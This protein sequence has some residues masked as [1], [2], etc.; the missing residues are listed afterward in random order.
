L[1]AALNK[2]RKFIGSIVRN[3]YGVWWTVMAVNGDGAIGPC[4]L[5]FC[6]LCW[7]PAS[8][9]LLF[10]R[11]DKSRLNS[12]KIN[13]TILGLIIRNGLFGFIGLDVLSI[14]R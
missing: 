4:G 13:E 12:R 2:K 8:Y 5:F 1:H 9:T 14:N 11:L 10:N 3:N 7:Y 6:F